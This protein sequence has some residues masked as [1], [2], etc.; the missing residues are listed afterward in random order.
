MKLIK[1]VIAFSVGILLF[2]QS[3]V[4]QQS[5]S[6]KLSVE[7]VQIEKLESFSNG[8]GVYLRWNTTYEIN[9]LGF[10][11]YRA[12]EKGKVLVNPSIIA[13]SA[14]IVGDKREMNGGNNYSW[15]DAK[16]SLS[17]V[18]YIESFNT[19]GEKKTFG[20]IYSQQVSD[21]LEFAE[22]NSIL[23][24]EQKGNAAAII[25]TSNPVLPKDLVLNK[26]R[27][28]LATAQET[29]FWVAA[30]PGVKIGIKKDGF[31]RV[32]R[33]DLQTAGFNVNAPI[34]KWQVYADGV[35]Q[36]IIVEPNGNYIEFYGRGID[37]IFSDTRNYFLVEGT[38]DGKR[39]QNSFRRPVREPVVARSFRDK[40][41]RS[42]NVTYANQFL[43]GDAD[44]FFGTSFNE[45]GI[46]LEVATPGVD[47]VV[48]K[49]NLEITVQGLT[50]VPHVI[51]VLLNGTEI[52]TMTGLNQDSITASFGV[53]SDLLIDGNNVVRLVSSAANDYS[54][55]DT[56]KIT[57]PRRYIA[58]QNSLSCYVP[59]YVQ[60]RIQGFSSSNIRVFDV[61]DLENLNLITNTGI[62]S[63]NGGFTAVIPSNRAKAFFA[64]EDS[65]I[66]S[67]ASVK[68]NTSSTWSDPGRTS[69]LIIITHADFSAQ[70]NTWA[71]YR[72]GQG[73]TVEVVDIEDVY[74]E[75]DFGT[76]GAPAIRNFLQHAYATRQT[77][78]NYIM[79]MGDAVYDGRNYS[80]LNLVNYVPSALVDTT[81]SQVGSDE[82]LADFDNDG[83]SEISIGRIPVKNA[84]TATLIYNKTV[85]FELTRATALS[86]GFLCA[87]DLPDGYDFQGICNRV[88]AELPSTVPKTFVNRGDVNSR[89]T[90]LTELNTGKFLVNYA[91]HG[92]TSVW[93]VASFYGSSDLQLMTNS[94]KLSIFT[95]LTCLNGYYNNV[96]SDG[97]AKTS[98]KSPNGGSVAAWASS[99]LTT[100]DVQEIMA[101]RFYNQ[102]GNG[103]IERMGD[104]VKDAKT[105]LT[106]GRDVRLSWVLLGDPTLRLR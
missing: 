36:P 53:T 47:P 72:R 4:S 84:A 92:H 102:L 5:K 42:F 40:V 75:F 20:P 2:N 39:I 16:G 38:Q 93:S 98:L 58:L 76:S 28:S 35:E 21:L 51:K 66:L 83:L 56:I 33:A 79:L 101:T 27:R 68:P 32:Q 44:N 52:G 23:L 80:G 11:I 81:Y 59:N 104:A 100:A 14:L 96:F 85:N 45:T 69:N 105:T 17:D 89:D 61:T 71:E 10:N 57:Y 34:S 70:A 41:T 24:S 55:S 31:Y 95:L 3:V 54:L 86:R 63:E 106:Y 30:Q 88:G 19:S 1:F 48:G 91:G 15:F 18:Y 77:R 99:G 60:T 22:G 46:N 13:G 103:N 73:M 65:G 29:Q 82:A 37:T 6:P 9:N 25:D 78:P 49:T 64:V 43:N 62:V 94:N 97:L 90:L 50:F 26:S 12:N 8:N 67:P 87:S 7:A 74:D